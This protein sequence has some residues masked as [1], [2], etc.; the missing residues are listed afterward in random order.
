[1][2]RLLQNIGNH[3][4]TQADRPIS[5]S[6]RV[7]PISSAP[8]SLPFGSTG[9]P[10]ADHLLHLQSTIGNRRVL[11]QLGK[12]APDAATAPAEGDAT[13]AVTEGEAA[14]ATP[15]SIEA[16]LKALK[17]YKPARKL[18]YFVKGK[19]YDS[20]NLELTQSD[21]DALVSKI[22]EIRGQI[23]ALDPE[24]LNMTAVA[25]KKKQ[26]D[27]YQTLAD[28]VPYSFQMGNLDIVWSINTA[29]K[30]KK[31]ILRIVTADPGPAT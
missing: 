22:G 11:R 16:E 29:G 14:D 25:L 21:R 9:N 24:K 18:R 3:P 31:N 12:S 20:S 30:G 15:E 27:Y 1:M 2:P 10:I 28:L 17:A 19:Y 4:S 8:L 26:G 13:P 6:S 7:A 5:R 23:A